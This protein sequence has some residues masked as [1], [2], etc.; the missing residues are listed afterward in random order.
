MI[1]QFIATHNR[2]LHSTSTLHHRYIFESFN[3][4][5]RLTGLIGAR[6]TGKT[7]LLLQYIKQ[8][9]AEPDE[10][11]YVTLDHI[12]FSHHS[13]LDFV[14]ELYEVE[15]IRYFFLD[16]VHKYADW[17]Q[18][19]KNIHDSY[20]D[21][22]LIFSGSS[23]IDLISG[24][25]DLSRRGVLFRMGGMSFREYLRF[26]GIADFAPVTLTDLLDSRAE[27]EQAVAEIPK[28]RGHFKRYLE[29]GYYPFYLEGTDSYHQKLQRVVEKTI[30]EDIATYYRLGTDKLPCLRRI[31][32][33]LATVPPGELNRNSIAKHLE[34][35][36]KTVQHYL[37]MLQETGLV[38]LLASA[39]AGGG[40]LKKT[41]KM[42]LDNPNLYSSINQEIGHTAQVGTIRELFFLK[43]L[44]NA[45]HVPHYS[46]TGDFT[47]E[48]CVF[49]VGGKGKTR[50]QIRQSEQPA[51]LVKDDVLY[52][53]KQ[54]I[55]LH[56]FG[57]LY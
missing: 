27:L 34:L 32:A 38:E 33:Y 44:K 18:A 49:E 42:Y 3:L 40:V 35:D 5:N 50:K 16:E 46:K 1:D 52:G 55:P 30:Y 21:I 11:L 22:H 28:L 24:A 47:V 43:M 15:G 31:L 48:G 23:S 37:V 29:Y 25:Y 54:A 13:L 39:Q 51:Y 53:G 45:G 4:N 2:L 19:L 7:T 8:K 10:A 36:N 9:L 57:F 20:P 17:N 56:L 12:Y 26:E 41:E 6:G 14:N